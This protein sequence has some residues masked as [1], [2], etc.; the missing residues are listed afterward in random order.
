MKLRTVKNL[1]VS[2]V[3]ALC[4]LSSVNARV[5]PE[6]A[7]LLPAET[8]LLININ[9]FSQFRN[10][11]EKSSIYKLQKDPAMAAFCSNFET[12]W[13]NK[14]RQSDNDFIKTIADVNSMPTGRVTLAL[15]LNEKTIKSNEPPIL[16]ITQWGTNIDK[17]KKTVNKMVDKAIEDGCRRTIE[18]HGSFKIITLSG[19]SEPNGI[20][21]SSD[22]LSYCFVDDCLVV[23]PD[24]ELVRF[25]TAHIAGSAGWSLVNLT[26]LRNQGISLPHQSVNHNPNYIARPNIVPRVKNDQRRPPATASDA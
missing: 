4:I 16:S 18:Q 1:I 13:R 10:Q 22:G 9:D 26:F 15:V 20:S 3:C 7:K 21:A 2:F 19:A 5:L 23:S 8:V 24:A 11:L 12:N 25:V 17:I 14:M 6:A